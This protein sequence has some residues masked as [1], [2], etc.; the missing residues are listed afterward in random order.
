MKRIRLALMIAAGLGA[1]VPSGLAGGRPAAQAGT[2]VPASRPSYDIRVEL[3]DAAKM[4]RGV[5]ELVWVNPTRDE[6]PDLRLHLYWNAF[7]NESST[8]LREAEEESFMSRGAAPKDGEWGWIDVT[9]IAL[10]DGTDLKPGL[11]YLAE[12]RPLRPDDQ[13]VLRVPLPSPVPPG[14]EVR[15]RIAFEAKIPRPVARSGYYRNS[16]FIAQWFPKP[17][18]YEEGK[19]WNCHA[20]HQRSEFYADFADFTVRMTVPEAFV[21][22]SSGLQTAAEK[23]AA[24]KTV[25]Y[26]FV[27]DRVHDFAWTADPRYL[28]IERDFIADAEVTPA[29]YDATARLL[30]LPLEEVKLPDVKMILLIEPEHRGQAERHFRALRNALKYYGLWY[31][32]YPYRT[33]TMVDPPFRT[34]SGGMEY[35]TLFTAGTSVVTSPSD[36]SPEMVIVHEFGHGYWYG[37][38][39]NNEFEEAWLDEGINTYS[40]GRVLARA[41]GPGT[42]PMSFKGVPLDRVIRRM[43][44]VYDWETNRAAAIH[45][46]ELDPVV[47]W[48]WRFYNSGSYAANVYMRASTLLDTLERFLGEETMARVMR[49]YHMRWRFRHPRTEDFA[50]VAAEVSGRDLAWFFAELF[51]ETWNFDYGLADLRSAVKPKRVRG[52]F[53]VAGKKDE[54][55][56]RRLA[57]LEK[58]ERPAKGEKAPVTYLTTA[59]LRRYGEARLG[60]GVSVILRVTFEDG[61]VQER[62][63]DG[64][65]R[66][67]CVTFETPSRAAFAEIDPDHVWLIDSNFANNSRRVKP[68]RKGVLRIGAGLVFML[69]NLLRGLGS[70]G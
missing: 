12:D 70:L 19:G 37:L 49:T 66:W 2:P 33:V 68:A 46:V 34:G 47:T 10:A 27:Q 38:V 59:T 52:V 56:R 1:A 69:Q 29:E 4:L 3:D 67:T 18:V 61:S 48:S 32:P 44:R 36:N 41:Y 35:P 63:W 8:F 16:Y 6:V 21:V 51:R 31:G 45:V 15:L 57:E 13:T 5:E 40:T 50:A 22:G 43:P 11:A 65:D 60:G 7:K 26:T 28:K 9:A 20:Y 25:T 55:T 30:G 58:K 14:G 62:R 54:M 42:L 64:R 39:A 23:D 24:R 17:G 53:D